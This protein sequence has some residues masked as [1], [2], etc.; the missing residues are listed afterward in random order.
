MIGINDVWRQFDTPFI[1][2]GHVY[3]E[4][5]EET[6][7]KLV[8]E[9]KPLVEGLVLMTTYYIENNEQDK[10]RQTMDQYGKVVR[11]IAEENDCYFI[12]TQSAFNVVLKDL[13]PATLA[14]D[15]VHLSAVGHMM[16]VRALLKEMGFEWNR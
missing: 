13:Y 16:L 14:W 1:K 10:M 12:D 11:K 3:L 5:Y 9:T 2:E 4:A 6:L 15:R 7:R 8:T